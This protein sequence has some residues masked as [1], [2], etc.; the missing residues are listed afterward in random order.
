MIN[1]LLLLNK[2]TRFIAKYM[3]VIL[4]SKCIFMILSHKTHNGSYLEFSCTH[5]NVAVCQTH[6]KVF[7]YF[8]DVYYT[9][10]K[11]RIANRRV[12]VYDAKS[13]SVYVD[14][15]CARLVSHVSDFYIVFSFAMSVGKQGT[16]LG[17]LTYKVCPHWEI[18][19]C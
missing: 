6:A 4:F 3:K 7:I 8:S 12:Y 5:T 2:M 18:V 13:V 19:Q 11:I 16:K 9:L 14:L 10:L 17:P 1:D 15:L